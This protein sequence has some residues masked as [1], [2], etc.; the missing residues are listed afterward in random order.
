[1]RKTILALTALSMFA[2]VPTFTAPHTIAAVQNSATD[3]PVKD[4]KDNRD[5]NSDAKT[6]NFTGTVI[7]LNGQRFIL[8]DDTLDTWYHLDDQKQAAQYLGKK[9]LVV[10]VMDERSDMIHVMSMQES[11][12]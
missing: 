7:S 1:M 3:N 4:S 6:Q 9:V 11:K 8:R 10:G 12:G 2:A 5:S